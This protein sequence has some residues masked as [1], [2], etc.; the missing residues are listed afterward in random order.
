MNRKSNGVGKPVRVK[1]TGE[2]VTAGQEMGKQ[3]GGPKKLGEAG[4]PI[5]ERAYA[6]R[7][8]LTDVVIV[9]GVT[10]IGNL[11]FTD[12]SLETLV[13]PSSVT[14]IGEGA[15]RGCTSLRSVV[16]PEDVTEIGPGAFEGCTS[17]A[18]VTIPSSVTGIGDSAFEG[19]TSLSMARVPAGLKVSKVSQFKDC[20]ALDKI[21][22]Y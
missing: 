20:P 8:D 19:C 10:G 7:K 13:I 6:D 12:S 1:I 16:I 9:E 14:E 3:A 5:Q 22:R 2:A 11:A 17:L 18:S 15:F 21:Q 4:S